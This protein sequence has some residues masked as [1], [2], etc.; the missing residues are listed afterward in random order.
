MANREVLFQQ[1]LI[2][3]VRLDSSQWKI[4]RDIKIESVVQDSIAFADPIPEITKYKQ[5]AQG[6]WE[7][8]LSGSMTGDRSGE[9][10]VLFAQDGNDYVGLV[11]AIIPQQEGN[12][13]A[14]TVQHT[15]VDK[16]HRGKGIG[17]DLLKSLIEQLR[18]KLDVSM[19]QLDV[20]VTQQVALGLYKKLGFKI[21]GF[22]PKKAKR[23]DKEYDRYDMVLQLR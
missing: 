20:V 6:E 18:L 12:Q 2:S 14:A 19:V 10:I 13:Q 4:L 7:A 15:F 11:T 23:G 1:D 5:R 17:E 22:T 8:A 3:I 9:S 21:V 16:N